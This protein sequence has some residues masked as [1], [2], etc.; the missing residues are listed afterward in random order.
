MKPMKIRTAILC[1]PVRDLDRTLAFYRSVFGLADAQID[2]GMIA[3]E[4]P[5]L[6]LFLMSKDSFETYTRKAGRDA[7]FPDGKAGTVISCAMETQQSVD[8]MLE[9]VPKHGGA[10]PAVAGMDEASGGYIGY[11]TDP[12]GYLWELVYPKPR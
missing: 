8:A 12:D 6:Y 2:E 4:L 7:Q 5:N 1:L 3:L 10:T 11:V 9:A